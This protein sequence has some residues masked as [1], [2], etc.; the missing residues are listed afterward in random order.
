[1]TDDYRALA[2]FVCVADNDG[3]TGAGKRLGL[4][5]SVVSHH[6]NRL[7][8]ALGTAL[9]YRSTRSM[10]LTPAGARMLEPARRMIAARNEAIDALSNQNA[11]PIGS[12]KVSITAF[13][14]E[15]SLHQ[16]ILAFARD[17]RRVKFELH[18]TDSMVDII[19]EGFD[20]AVRLGKLADSDLKSRKIGDFH[21]ILVASPHYL[22]S[23]PPI[24]T[25]EDLKHC[26]FLSFAMIP[27]GF[28]L[29]K[30]RKTIE[31]APGS[32][33]VQLDTIAA[34]IAAVKAGV[35]I[36]RL[37]ASEIEDDL[38]SGA[39]VRLLPDWSLPVQGVYAVW[40]NANPQ[41]RMTRT[42]IEAISAA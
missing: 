38:V 19:A 35:G 3:F 41:R 14:Y 39:L 24:K 31:V 6:I 20:V 33:R 21:R 11:E 28:K 17:N 2:I 34:V 25:P 8:E 4:S 15:T 9:F 10:S 26:E 42:F 30:G 23:L 12:L 22:K 16:R 36:Q 32:T 40:P 27:D 18:Y 13:G 7:E 37:P 1:M 29:S 5:P